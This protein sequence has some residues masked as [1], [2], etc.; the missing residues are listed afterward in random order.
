MPR[1][2]DFSASIDENGEITV[3]TN[4]DVSWT[5]Y[6]IGDMYFSKNWGVGSGTMQSFAPYYAKYVSGDIVFNFDGY[7]VP[8]ILPAM[9]YEGEDEIP[10][11][12]NKYLAVT[13]TLVEI[14]NHN[15]SGY[16][17]VFFNYNNFT[18]KYD[19]EIITVSPVNEGDMSY[20]SVT[21]EALDS[22][23]TDIVFENEYYTRMC[24]HVVYT[25]DFN[26]LITD[27]E[28]SIVE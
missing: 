20:L 4:E 16:M 1:I 10:I 24:V 25:Y 9:V 15:P 22:F 26:Y 5:C 14:N 7:D 19:E 8:Y 18:V 13:P 3:T 28:D 12:N 17:Y 6:A 2:V 11:L 21:T 23:E 27:E